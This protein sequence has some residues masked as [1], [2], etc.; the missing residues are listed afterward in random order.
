MKTEILK[1]CEEKKICIFTLAIK[2][3]WDYRGLRGGVGAGAD[4]GGNLFP[5]SADGSLCVSD[6]P[7]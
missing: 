4:T 7:F 1:A 3:P 2:R 5:G 6:D